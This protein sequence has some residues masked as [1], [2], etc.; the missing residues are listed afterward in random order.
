M[1][2]TAEHTVAVGLPVAAEETEAERI[3]QGSHIGS[4]GQP[5]V[6]VVTDY[7]LRIGAKAAGASSSARLMVV[8][9]A[10]G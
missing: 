8:V 6:Q 9:R 5:P 2:L 4:A 7:R 1:S 10:A 3:R